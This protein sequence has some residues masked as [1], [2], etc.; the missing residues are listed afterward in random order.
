[1]NGIGSEYYN[2]V[3]AETAVRALIRSLR[4]LGYDEPRAI[5]AAEIILEKAGSDGL[6]TE[7]LWH[8]LDRVAPIPKSK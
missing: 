6:K 5:E 3:K 7:I 2:R 8:A 1:M 4:G